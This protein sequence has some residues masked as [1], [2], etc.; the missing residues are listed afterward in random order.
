ME[1]EP[2][3]PVRAVTGRR[4]RAVVAV[5]L[6]RPRA[7]E[8]GRAVAALRAA[9]VGHLPLDGVEAVR[10]AEALCGDDLLAGERRGGDQA[11]VDRGPLGAGRAVGGWPGD[12]DAAGTALT[13]GAAF[14]GAGQ[15]AVAQEVERGGV[16]RRALERQRF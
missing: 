4:A 7:H 8:A 3:L 15:P 5:V 1:V 16:R 11:G 10:R 9:S 14:L 12:Q 2:V 13:L 6:R